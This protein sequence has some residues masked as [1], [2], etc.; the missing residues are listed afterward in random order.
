MKSIEY[1]IQLFPDK[2][3]RE[4]LEIQELEKKEEEKKFQKRLAKKLSLIKDIKEN[5]GYFK[6]RFGY[7]QR[8]YYKIVD[9]KLESEQIYTTVE[10][11]IVFINEHNVKHLTTSIDTF[12]IEKRV[13]K[14]VRWEDYYNDPQIQRITKEEWDELNNYCFGITKFWDELEEFKK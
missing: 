5:G 11:I 3:G 1:L 2:T 8:Y 6:G 9:I 13:D 4:I 14:L 7:D 10:Q 12:N